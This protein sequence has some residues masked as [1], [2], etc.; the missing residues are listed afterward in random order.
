MN[1]VSVVIA[2]LGGRQLIETIDALNSGSVTPEEI[3]V[4]VP[5]SQEVDLGY[6]SATNVRVVRTSERGQVVQRAMGF[7]QV[8][9]NLVLQLD[10]DIIMEKDALLKLIECIQQSSSYAIGPKLIDLK[11]GIYQSYLIPKS[12]RHTLY[13]RLQ[14]YII[15]GSKGFQPGGIAKAGVCMGVPDDMKDWSGLDWLPGGCML[16]HKENLV[17][18][19]FYPFTG[20]AYAEDL[21]H[22]ICLRKK[23][24]VLVRCGKA[25]CYLNNVFA[26][27][28]GAVRFF[29]EQK[30]SVRALKKVVKQ[31]NGSYARLYIFILIQS[32]RLILSKI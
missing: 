18:Y 9:C 10:D 19:N 15:N 1:G 13:E 28:I 3:L 12:N 27:R 6:L 23:N 24:I 29:E 20:K 25:K 30:R 22:S 32:A 14:Y 7:N 5:E 2:T 11:T 16:H 4:C 17:L 31:I 26:P 8:K 21:F